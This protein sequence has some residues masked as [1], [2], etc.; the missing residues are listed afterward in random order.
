LEE[1]VVLSSV[2]CLVHVEGACEI[3]VLAVDLLELMEG[4]VIAIMGCLLPSCIC[5]QFLF[6]EMF[7]VCLH[8]GDAEKAPLHERKRCRDATL[9]GICDDNAGHFVAP[10][11]L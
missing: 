7:R 9:S 8:I 6:A 3:D 10:L 2:I 4:P 11:A 1:P 5:A